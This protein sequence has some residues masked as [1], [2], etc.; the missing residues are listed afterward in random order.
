MARLLEQLVGRVPAK[1]RQPLIRF[2]S[3]REKLQEE[4]QLTGPWSSRE[5]IQ[6]AS[7]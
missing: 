2:E 7:S 1:K 5:K 4:G 6:A 3:G